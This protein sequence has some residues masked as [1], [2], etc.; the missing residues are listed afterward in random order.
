MS[1][2]GDLNGLHFSEFT[3]LL[4]S[5]IETNNVPDEYRFIEFDMYKIPIRLLNEK[6]S[7]FYTEEHFLQFFNLLTLNQ[8]I[9]NFTSKEIEQTRFGNSNTTFIELNNK[10]DN[11][12]ILQVGQLDNIEDFTEY[13]N[14]E[15]RNG[16][17]INIKYLKTNQVAKIV[18]VRKR[19]SKI[20][21]KGEY[22]EINNNSPL[23][24]ALLGHCTN[25][26]VKMGEKV[27]ILI[28][29]VFNN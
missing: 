16:S 25:E 10:P 27:E 29:D 22:V 15:I 8:D 21:K 3:D 6:K 4:D 19:I 7:I 17:R 12:S 11:G 20:Y 13:S 26:I 5:S 28:E 9:H 2:I 14:D 23:A 24:K 1:T 18:I